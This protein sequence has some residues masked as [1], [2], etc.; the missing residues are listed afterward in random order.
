MTRSTRFVSV[1]AAAAGILAAGLVSAAGDHAAMNHASRKF[2]GIKANTGTVT[3]TY[4]DGHDVLSL[5]DD[6]KTPDTPAPHWQ[7][8]D[9]R[10]NTY[11]LQRLAIKDNKVNRSI[12]VPAYVP[13]VVKVQIWCAWAQTLLG[14]ASFERAVK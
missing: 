11:L 14:E 10:G 6:F 5:S 9:S 12:V 3:H 7:L 13:D 8:V 1:C 4:T 2:N